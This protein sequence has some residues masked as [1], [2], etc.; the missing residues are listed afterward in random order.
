MHKILLT[1]KISDK[2]ALLLRDQHF[3]V[4][5]LPTMPRE[6]LLECLGDYHAIA[7][8]SATLIDAELIA[9]LPNVKLIVRGGVGVD[10]IDIAAA[11]KAGIA[12]ANTPGANTIA[13]AELTFS[14]LLN[15]ARNV[16]AAHD[17]MVDGKWQRAAFAGIEL[18]GRTL[19]VLGFGRI[20][21]EVALRAKAFGMHVLAYD[22]FLP[23][24]FLVERGVEQATFETAIRHADF[25]SLHLPLDDAT[26]HILDATAFASM[27]LG[28]RVVNCAR[29]GLIDENAAAEALQNGQLAGLALDVYET[30]PPAKENPLIGHPGVVHV[31]HLGA[32]T[33]EAQA[34]VADEVAEVMVDFFVNEKYANILNRKEL[35]LE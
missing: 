25:I 15:L 17:S 20:G 28:V 32:S 19:A 21:R 26:Q 7:I 24:A 1:D 5:S 3:E 23:E 13:T 18:C 16:V 14:M 30:E 33:A 8:R 12:V 29:G 34:K 22:P 2:A 6:K 10:N 27:K 9:K 4:D 35:S 11:S 31:P